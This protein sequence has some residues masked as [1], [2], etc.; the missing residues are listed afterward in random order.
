MDA[1][2]G[3]G[4]HQWPLTLVVPKGKFHIQR[5]AAPGC[6]QPCY[7]NSRGTGWPQREAECGSRWAPSGLIQLGS[8]GARSQVTLEA[9]QQVLLDTTA[10]VVL[11]ASILCYKI[12]NTWQ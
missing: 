3:D 8:S 11:Y 10:R 7:W 1:D 9:T 6:S 12:L 4:P 2:G 5:Q